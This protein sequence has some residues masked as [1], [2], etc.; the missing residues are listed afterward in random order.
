MEVKVRGKKFTECSAFNPTSEAP[1]LRPSQ[2]QLVR[3]PQVPTA[4]RPQPAVSGVRPGVNE[5]G[6][7]T[8]PHR[9]GRRSPC[10][11]PAS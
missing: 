6:G 8:S 11:S 10:N 3:T 2:L 5:M 9:P 1:G 7:E 4:L